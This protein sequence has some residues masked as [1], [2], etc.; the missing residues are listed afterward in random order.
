MLAFLCTFYIRNFHFLV[1]RQK[2]M[3]LMFSLEPNN[4]NMREHIYCSFSRQLPLQHP[5]GCLFIVSCGVRCPLPLLWW[6]IF[7]MPFQCQY[8]DLWGFLRT[9]VFTARRFC[10]LIY[11]LLS[12]KEFPVMVNNFKR[13]FWTFPFLW[14]MFEHKKNIFLIAMCYFF[15]VARPSVDD[16]WMFADASAQ[17]C[18][19]ISIITA[20]WCTN[21]W[22]I[23]PEKVIKILSPDCPFEF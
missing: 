20:R 4:F 15:L 5:W 23:Q 13:F 1:G 12:L 19:L 11:N 9:F 21:L 10:S 22:S 18:Q 16:I 8:F 6:N 2:Q 3:W 14:F 17:L 7:F